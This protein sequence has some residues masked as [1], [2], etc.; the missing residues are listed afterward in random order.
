MSEPVHPQERT[1]SAIGQAQAVERYLLEQ[2]PCADR[3]ESLTPGQGN[4]FSCLSAAIVRLDSKRFFLSLSFHVSA[5]QLGD[6]ILRQK[7]LRRIGTDTEKTSITCGAYGTA[8]GNQYS[9]P[10]G[11]P[12]PPQDG[13]PTSNQSVPSS[14]TRPSGMLFLS[15]CD[16]PGALCRTSRESFKTRVILAA[17][18]TGG[19]GEALAR[20]HRKRVYLNSAHQGSKKKI[21]TRMW[22]M[23]E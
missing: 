18:A 5:D 10:D 3:S 17:F 19:R 16:N 2:S 1:L 23:N 7:P 13:H 9:S 12:A 15:P 11:S 21:A 22:G 14:M 20:G 4:V 6:K 8:T